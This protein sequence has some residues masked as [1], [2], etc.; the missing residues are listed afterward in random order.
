MN[1][2]IALNGGWISRE[3]SFS[4]VEKIKNAKNIDDVSSV[5]GQIKD[6]FCGTNKESAKKELFKLLSPATTLNEKKDAFNNLKN[7]AGAAHARDFIVGDDGSLKIVASEKTVFSLAVKN[8]SYQGEDCDCASKSITED[9]AKDVVGS[10][11]VI[12][13]QFDAD[14][15]R[16]SYFVN[17]EEINGDGPEGKKNQLKEKFELT[18]EIK[19]CL[20]QTLFSTAYQFLSNKGIDVSKAVPGGAG[21]AI[22][23]YDITKNEGNV[24]SV[25]A[26]SE[27]DV[28]FASDMDGFDSL[29]LDIEDGGDLLRYQKID[30]EVEINTLLVNVNVKRITYISA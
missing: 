13:E 28:A 26:T 6:W 30:I 23:R 27:K 18:R 16:G 17:G 20:S 12:S 19:I 14:I 29:L 11:N 22:L 7:M 8:E 2:A 4:D 9:I 3:I 5:W 24:I 25:K 1:T 21:V 15:N 10:R